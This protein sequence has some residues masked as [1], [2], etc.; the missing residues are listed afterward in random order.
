[1]SSPPSPDRTNTSSTNPFDDDSVQ[2]LPNTGR[3]NAIMKRGELIQGVRSKVSPNGRESS[4]IPSSDIEALSEAPDSDYASHV[5]RSVWE[6]HDDPSDI[7]VQATGNLKPKQR[8]KVWATLC[9]V[10]ILLVGAVIAVAVLV[11]GK[12]SDRGVSGPNFTAR[13]QLIDVLVRNVTEPMV[14]SNEESPQAKAL[15]WLLYKDTLWV[16]LD[17]DEDLVDPLVNQARIT[18]RYALVVFFYSTGGESWEESTW[19]LGDECDPG[20]QW[21]GV[22]CIDNLVH[23][24]ALGKVQSNNSL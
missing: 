20:A 16:H 15:E 13:Q 7:R 24:L 2:S 3:S 23:T 9:I 21:T 19:L 22:V 8:T 17:E 11:F 6:E 18:Q 1:M 10:S 5:P 12:G 4:A 14:L